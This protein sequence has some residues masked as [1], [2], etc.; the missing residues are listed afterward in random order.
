MHLIPFYLVEFLFG[1]TLTTFFMINGISSYFNG[2]STLSFLIFLTVFGLGSFFIGIFYVSL[3][4]LFGRKLFYLLSLLGLSISISF[5]MIG[6]FVIYFSFMGMFIFGLIRGGIITLSF[7]IIAH[8]FEKDNT[9]QFMILNFSFYAGLSFGPLVSYT[10]LNTLDLNIFAYGILLASSFF[11]F[12]F[13]A[14][15]LPPASVINFD[16]Y[17]YEKGEVLL[18]LFEKRF[19]INFLLYVFASSVFR[20][21]QLVFSYFFL[22]E[23]DFNQV[24]IPYLY[25]MT[26][27][28]QVFFRELFIKLLQ[29]GYF[30][31]RHIILITLIQMTIGL[32]LISDYSGE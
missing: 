14:W 16:F 18:V 9:R 20:S 26:L 6:C 10:V 24:V 5:L 22:F 1:A 29:I 21:I 28:A 4:N 7:S 19:F 23:K 27:L 25:C 13:S 31:H 11:L 17:K 32:F 3:L 12:I 15:I 2:E 30:K 8:F